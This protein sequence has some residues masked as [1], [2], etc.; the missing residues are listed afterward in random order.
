MGVNNSFYDFDIKAAK[1]GSLVE[2]IMGNPV[3]IVS[4]DVKDNNYPILALVTNDS[5]GETVVKY[6]SFGI[7]S[8]KKLSLS[9]R[10]KKVIVEG[11]INLYFDEKQKIVTSGMIVHRTPKSADDDAGTSRFTKCKITWEQI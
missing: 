8:D 9:L 1:R 10:M 11:W 6:D 7:S 5:G 2:T 3:R 4:F